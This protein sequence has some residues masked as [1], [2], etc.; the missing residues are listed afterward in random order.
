MI[1]DFLRLHQQEL[2]R[3]VKQ[4]PKLVESPQTNL[5][6]TIANSSLGPLLSET[7]LVPFQRVDSTTFGR[8][9][10]RNSLLATTENVVVRERQ[11][12]V[13][14]LR[15]PVA[16][17]LGKIV[18]VAP[19][20]MCVEIALEPACLSVPFLRPGRI[21]VQ[22]QEHTTQ[23]SRGHETPNTIHDRQL[24]RSPEQVGWNKSRA[25]SRLISPI[26][27]RSL[28]PPRLQYRDSPEASSSRIDQSRATSADR[29]LCG[30]G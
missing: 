10:L 24:Y 1:G 29:P 8:H 14:I 27:P 5:G 16:D 12:V 3:S 11:E 23:R 17:H 18:S 7:C 4:R 15:V 6:Q 19:Q 2:A 20:R 30:L 22:G 13:V 26:G 21:T 9:F 25:R 28:A